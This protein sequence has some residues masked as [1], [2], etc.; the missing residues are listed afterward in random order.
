M[1][2]NLKALYRELGY[3]GPLD[4]SRPRGEL[5]E[6]PPLDPA[7]LSQMETLLRDQPENFLAYFR[8][9]YQYPLA[10]DQIREAIAELRRAFDDP[11]EFVETRRKQRDTRP[12]GKKTKFPAQLKLYPDI[13]VNPDDHKFEPLGDVLGWIVNSGYY[14]IRDHFR[15]TYS[16]AKIRLHH[17]F[18][19]GF[20]YAMKNREGRPA[21]PD[22]KISIALF[23]D[24]GTGVYHSLYIARNIAALEPDYAIHLGDVYYAGRA[25]EFEKY[26][27]KPLAPVVKGAR[28]FALNANHEMNSGAI[29]YFAN[30]ETRQKI[31]R[32]WMAQEQEGSYFCIWNQKYQII[33]I[34]TAYYG[35]GTH[36]NAAVN[37]WLG[38]CLREGKS[39]GRMNIL[40]SQNE[41]YELGKNEFAPVYNDL[42]PFIQS[43][44][45]DFWFWGNTHYCALFKKSP[46]APFI[47]SCIGHA[48]HPIYKAEVEKNARRH[49][50]QIQ[51]GGALPEAEWVDLSPKFPERLPKAAGWKNPRPELGNHGFCMLALE[52][53]RLTLSYCDWLQQYKKDFSF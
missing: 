3:L 35:S 10:D 22:Q 48:G 6:P 20:K 28:F 36:P 24:F 37:A 8:H 27:N 16:K 23:S 12:R 39:Q 40:L 17:E 4:D 45:I 1:K 2:K 32:G 19:S 49:K 51:K 41:P 15:I 42:K 25:F 43:Q 34:D 29:P 47:G 44:L 31:K 14:F 5:E 11:A 46:Q 33:G 21:D 50:E 13:E 30:L 52:R 38:Q 26:F 53:N 9:Q 18:P 7:G